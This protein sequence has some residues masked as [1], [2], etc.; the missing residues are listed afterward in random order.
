VLGESAGRV[1]ALGRVA[2][3]TETKRRIEAKRLVEG[4]P[5]GGK[6]LVS[7]RFST[8]FIL[9]LSKGSE[10]TQPALTLQPVK[11]L[12]HSV[13]DGDAV[14]SGKTGGGGEDTVDDK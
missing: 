5:V 12:R 10:A 2:K 3:R 8:E 13:L 7:I 14:F 4:A 9:S 1:G 11:D 6:R